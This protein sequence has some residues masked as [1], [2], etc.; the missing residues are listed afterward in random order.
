MG[1]WANSARSISFIYFSIAFCLLFN[2]IHW[3]VMCAAHTHTHTAQ[4]R[5]IVLYA[6]A[7]VVIVNGRIEITLSAYSDIQIGWWQNQWKPNQHFPF[8]LKRTCRPFNIASVHHHPRN[9]INSIWNIDAFES[10]GFI[11]VH[12][13]LIENGHENRTRQCLCSGCY[14]DEK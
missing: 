13:E 10:S 7:V 1:M 9:L 14:F 12:T 2:M 6:V 11:Y 3:W 5:G 8:S 4:L